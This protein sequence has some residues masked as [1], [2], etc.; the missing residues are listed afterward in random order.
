MLVSDCAKEDSQRVGIV[1]RW[2]LIGPLDKECNRAN[3]FSPLSDSNQY[4]PPCG[5]LVT[6]SRKVLSIRLANRE[7]DRIGGSPTKTRFGI[8]LLAVGSEEEQHRETSNVRP[9][10]KE[11]YFDQGRY[12][13]ASDSFDGK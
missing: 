7:Q 4:E 12:A 1:A 10:Q 13:A 5:S 6:S 9:Q 11:N 3:K 8:S 2:L